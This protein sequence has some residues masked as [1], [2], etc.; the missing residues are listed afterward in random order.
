[1]QAGRLWELRWYDFRPSDRDR[2]LEGFQ[3][4]LQ[5]LE[6]T[7]PVVG[8]WTVD[9]GPVAGRIY[10][11]M[12]FRDWQHREDIAGS[13]RSEEVAFL[14]GPSVPFARGVKLLEPAHFS[15]LH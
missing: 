1:M 15:T 4:V 11:L 9:V 5:K 2:A 14:E 13:L 3:P 12:P 10:T 6:Q 7:L 8:C